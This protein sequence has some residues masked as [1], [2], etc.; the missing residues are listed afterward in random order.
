MA[1]K[2]TKAV[3]VALPTYTVAEFA[4]A[5]ESVGATSKDLVNA[6]FSYAGKKEAT[7]EEAKEIV[8]KFKNKEVK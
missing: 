1:T 8:K 7:V 4:S 6:A 2:E 5:P 3:Q